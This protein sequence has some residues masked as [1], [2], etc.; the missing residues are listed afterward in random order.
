MRLLVALMLLAS[1]A[2]AQQDPPFA[3]V[4]SDSSAVVV[5][6]G[7]DSVW[8]M[9]ATPLK[10]Y[11]AHGDSTSVATWAPAMMGGRSVPELVEQSFTFSVR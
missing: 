2:R 10:S 11:L 6:S 3:S 4:W 9:A 1:V 5:T 7:S 8:I